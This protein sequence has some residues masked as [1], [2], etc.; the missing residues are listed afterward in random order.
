MDCPNRTEGYNFWLEHFDSFDVQWSHEI[1]VT[2]PDPT[3]FT[4]VHDFVLFI[5]VN[6]LM[7]DSIEQAPTDD[8]V[9][10]DDDFWDNHLAQQL[11]WVQELITSY[12]NTTMFGYT[13]RVVLF[14]HPNPRSSHGVFFDGL[15]EFLDRTYSNT[16][17]VIY[18][19]GDGHKWLYEP[20]FK[21]SSGLL[22]IQVQGKA[23]EPPT[24]ITVFNTGE[25]VVVVDDDDVEAAFQYNRQLDIFQ[26]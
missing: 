11:T 15:T 23:Q 7:P 2:R 13:G 4:F 5:G 25:A 9:R 19:N 22:R 12:S 21:G 1:E 24:L 16:L 20:G 17:P 3:T 14:G 6:L 18:V 26:T 10:V 8:D